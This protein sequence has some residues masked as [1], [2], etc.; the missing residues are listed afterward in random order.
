VVGI[1]AAM[2][3]RVSFESKS[4]S[5]VSGELAE[6][7]GS[8]KVGSVVLVQEYWGLNDHVRDLTARMANEGFLVLA[9]DLYHGKVTKDAT[10]AAK[11]MAELDTLGAVKEIDGAVRYLAKHPRSNGKVGVMGFCMGGALSLAS[12]CHVEGLSA[13][14]S[15]YGIPPAEKVDYAKV[16]APVMAHVATKDEWVTV[17]KV[18]EI[19]QQLEGRGHPME[20]HVYEAQHA[21]VND[22]RPAV[23]D[24]ANA[25]LAWGR[26]VAFLRRHLA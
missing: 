2:T 8:G 7:S 6:P 19:E 25:K 10:E 21:F 22:T 18:E 11:L 23:H 15:F 9:P 4:G 20:V 17:A 26:T 14:V 5:A 3:T 16:T 12:A 24:P 1:L 13:V